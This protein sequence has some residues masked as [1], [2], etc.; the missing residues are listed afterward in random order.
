MHVHISC[1]PVCG[2]PWWVLLQQ[3]VSCNYFSPS[4][5][6]LHAFSA[7]CMY[8]KFGHHPHPL[9]YLCAKLRFFRGLHYWARPWRRITYSITQS[10]ISSFAALGTDARAL[11]N[12]SN[13]SP[14]VAISNIQTTCHAPDFCFHSH[15]VCTL[16]V[17][18]SDQH[19]FIIGSHYT[20]EEHLDGCLSAAR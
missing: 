14:R 17:L 5:L 18:N 7:V 16:T 1:L 20:P 8:S 19:S 9:G 10:L 3:S 11:L 2:A 6:L 12:I 15:G 4:T 13:Q